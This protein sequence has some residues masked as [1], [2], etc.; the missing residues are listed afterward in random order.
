[1]PRIS[2]GRNTVCAGIAA[3][4]LAGSPVLAAIGLDPPVLE[5]GRPGAICAN[6]S[7]SIWQL[8][9]IES[10]QDPKFQCLGL[11]L[12]GDIVK[13]IRLETHNFASARRRPD[14]ERI[15]IAE[16]S[17]AVVESS[18]GAV[19]DGV[20]GHDAI[21]LKG[22]LTAPPAKAEL[23]TT[24][25]YNGFTNEYRSCRITLEQAP[26]AGW[27]LVNRDDQPVLHIEIKTREMPMIGTFGIAILE[28]ACTGRDR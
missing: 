5:A 10:G 13:A 27:R 7:A 19:L 23:V 22:H 11:S 12:D 25:L 21:I 16:F 2:F 8:A 15:E 26:D 3:L 1:M 18:R 17:P 24:Y 6:S 20:P 4:V 9:T 28:G 14:A